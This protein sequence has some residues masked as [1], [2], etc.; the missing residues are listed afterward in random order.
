MLQA[1]YRLHTYSYN[2]HVNLPPATEGAGRR[3]VAGRATSGVF[4]ILAGRRSSKY[5]RRKYLSRWIPVA[6]LE[7]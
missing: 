2:D 3:A 7:G 1:T 4:P 6:R 5:F